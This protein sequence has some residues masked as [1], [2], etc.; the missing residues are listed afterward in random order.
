[1]ETSFGN[2]VRHRRKGLDLTQQEL[3]TRVGCSLSA[4]FKIESD[5]RRPSRQIAELL[6]QHLEIPSDQR[7]LFLKVARLVKGIQ[8]LDSLPPLSTPQLPSVT[9]QTHTNLPFSLTPLIGRENEL[10]AVIQQIKIP[11]CRLLT[12][13]GPGGVGKTRLSLE[14]AH[15]LQD[16]FEHRACFVSLAGTSSSEF[17]IPVIAEA[18]GFAFSGTSELKA[19]LFNYLR[20]KHILLVLDNLEHLLNGIELLDELLAFAPRVKL[21][22]TSREPLNL[23][24]EWAFE[25]QG[26]PVPAN[27][28][29]KDLE[30]NSA[31]ALFIRRARQAKANFTPT[32]GDTQA[33]VQICRLVEG[34]P[35]GLELAAS[36]VRM[37]SATEIALEIERSLDFLTTTARDVPQRH[38]SIRAVFDYS[39]NLLTEEEQRILRHL[40]VFSGGFT[41]EAAEHVANAGISQLS[42][43]VDK[44][45]LRHAG[46]HTGWYDFHELVRQYV[47]L[48][49]LE[50][51]EEYSQLHERHASFYAAWLHQLESQLQGPQQE[52]TLSRIS[53]DIDNVR[54]AWDRM[55]KYQQT[56]NLQHSLESVF[57]FHDIR[58]WLHQGAALF[59]HAV[60]AWLPFEKVDDEGDPN[61]IL[62]GELM[63]CHGHMVWHLGQS[64]K[65]RELLQRSLKLLGSHRN[66]PMLA[67]AVLYLSL[68]EHSQGNYAAA[69]NYAEECV[70]LNQGMGRDFGTGYALSNLGMVCLTE[71]RH[72]TAYACFKESMAVTR[73][74]N[75]PRAAAI[76]LSR[77][78]LAALRL[79]KLDE[80]Q[81]SLEESLATTRKL[82]DR[83]GTGNAL[84]YSGWLALKL[85]NLERAESCMRESVKLAEEDGDQ[86]LLAWTLTD[87]G[88]V[89]YERHADPGV[90]EIFLHAL[91]V[92]L[93]SQN[94]PAALYALVGIANVD[95]ELGSAEQALQLAR[96]SWGHPSSNYQTKSRAEKLCAALE[97]KLA[98]QQIETVQARIQGKTLDALVQEVL[99]TH[100][101]PQSSTGDSL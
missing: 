3:A 11:S 27:I 72:E 34:L 13:T 100:T 5:E 81:K 33:I 46:V 75:H 40:A 74:I 49:A 20:D 24:A 53:L 52:E 86:I 35:L 88:F 42:A 87:M 99:T 92:A 43:L 28:E 48:K 94:I 58:N 98:S 8:N 14:V 15:Q 19:Q 9:N 60:S 6:A 10:R 83:W 22:T 17:I 59:D 51:P 37:M 73:S 45:L 67:E 56:S 16:A 2:W 84:N 95:A 23:R 89:L 12:I 63:V 101:Q 18:L 61:R 64:Q 62:L 71:G 7:A 69:R 41:R 65:A 30:S 90:R 31:A 68:L 91:Q 39:W 66:R 57:V 54:S 70:A 55:V 97:T 80:A 38:R 26:L 1:M 32:L 76:N 78:G 36:W 82:H 79:G 47:E 85:G 50:N 21:L 77:L 96:Y 44:S 4:I 29:L 93:Q 25:V